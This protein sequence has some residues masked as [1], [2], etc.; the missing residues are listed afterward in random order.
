MFFLIRSAFWLCLVILLIPG[1]PESG[2]EAPRVTL[3]QAVSAAGAAIADLSQFCG[4]NPDACDTGGRALSII[5]EKAWQGTEFV[6]GF[7]ASQLEKSDET[8]S[9]TT[10]GTLTAADREIPW[11]APGNRRDTLVLASAP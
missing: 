9:P 6:V 5:G 10:V 8:P 4:R 7:L 11:Q 2:R 1:N 3:G